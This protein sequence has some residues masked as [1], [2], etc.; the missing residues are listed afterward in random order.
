MLAIELRMASGMLLGRR[1]LAGQGG[2]LDG[3][4]GCGAGGR[5]KDD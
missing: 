3:C 2:K 4:N 5:A 1:L